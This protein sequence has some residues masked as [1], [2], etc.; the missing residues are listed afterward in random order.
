MKIRQV[1][2]GVFTTIEDIEETLT[3]P[4][5]GF[6]WIDAD[7]EDLELL[8]PYTICMTWPLR[9]A[10]AKRSSARRLKFMKAIIL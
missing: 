10:S 8:Q 2:A 1:N 4:T 9:I 6:Y 3:A 7:I 5:E